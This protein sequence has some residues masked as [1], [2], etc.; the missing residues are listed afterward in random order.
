MPDA[1]QTIRELVTGFNQIQQQMGLTPLSANMVGFTPPQTPA[2]M[3]Q[4]GSKGPGDIAAE[5]AAQMNQ[6]VQVASRTFQAQSQ[7][8]QEFG[9]RMQNIKAQY[10]SPQAAQYMARTSGAP[11]FGTGGPLGDFPSPIYQT[12][13]EMGL[14]RPTLPPPGMRQPSG[15]AGTGFNAPMPAPFIPQPYM[16]LFPGGPYLGNMMP[17]VFGGEAPG[18]RFGEPWQRQAMQQEYMGNRSFSQAMAVTPTAFTTLPGAGLGMAGGA[19]MGARMGGA[20]GAVIGAGL[21]MVGGGIAGQP[22]FEGLGFGQLGEAITEPMVRT[23]AFGNQLE[24]MSRQ[25]VT[26]GPDLHALGRGLAQRPA[27]ETANQMQKMVERGEM[28]EFN[29]RDMMKVTGLAAQGGMMDMAQSG[30]QIASQARNI[31]RALQNFMQIAEE[32]DIQRAMQMMAHM[33]TMGMT[34]PETQIA[35]RNAQQFARMAGT[36][37][38]GLMSTAGAQGAM[39]FQQQ[40]LTGALGMEVGM[41]AAGM[42]RAAIAGGSFNPAQLALAGGQQ[43]LAQ[44]MME[45]SAANLNVRFPMMAA[46]SRNEQGELFVDPQRLEKI[47]S[48]KADLS[49]QIEMA[50]ANIDRLARA[51]GTSPE[52]VIS[53]ISSRTRELQD[54]M[55]RRLGPQGA[56]NMIIRQAL[57]IQ[58][59][60]GGS[61]DLATAIRSAS[62]GTMSINSAQSLARAAQNPDYWSSQQQSMLTDVPRL[63]QLEAARR[64]ATVDTADAAT[65]R[66]IF[67]PAYQAAGAVSD[68]GEGFNETIRDLRGGVASWFTGGGTTASGGRRFET[69]RRIGIDDA[70]ARREFNREL[71]GA[72][73]D[74][75]L[76]E[77]KMAGTGTRGEALTWQQE[78]S[79]QFNV[80]KEVVPAALTGGSSLAVRGGVAVAGGLVPDHPG[81]AQSRIVAQAR[82]RGGGWGTMAEYAPSITNLALAGGRGSRAWMGGG[83]TAGMGLFEEARG[84]SFADEMERKASGVAAFAQRSGAT[85]TQLKEHAVEYDRAAGEGG[86]ER[87]TLSRATEI[88]GYNLADRAKQSRVASMK[89]GAIMGSGMPII[90][91][92]IGAAAGY[93]FGKPENLSDDQMKEEYIKAEIEATGQSRAQVEKRVNADWNDPAKGSKLRDQVR[94]RMAQSGT[95]EAK[96]AV[97]AAEAA[98]GIG[99]AQNI[100]EAR[101]EAE[102]ALDLSTE[103]AISGGGVGTAKTIVGHAVGGGLGAAAGTLL[104]GPLGTVAGYLLGSSA[105]RKAAGPS[106]AQKK[107]FEETLMREKNDDVVLLAAANALEEDGDTTGARNIKDSIRAKDPDKYDALLEAARKMPGANDADKKKALAM[108]GK[109]VR[110]MSA[111]EAR[112]TTAGLREETKNIRKRAAFSE[113]IQK[114]ADEERRSYADVKAS[115]ETDEGLRK[116][117]QARAAEGGGFEA[118]GRGAGG[119]GERSLRKSTDQL[120][121]LGLDVAQFNKATNNLLQA[122]ENFKNAAIAGGLGR[123]AG[124]GKR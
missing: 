116:K 39:V 58:Q 34:V 124:Q 41:G 57:N 79:S 83:L 97:A 98:T 96:A 72:E 99:A 110:D 73:G 117:V 115:I 15:A 27:I 95:P 13:A 25:F 5:M 62:G 55:G 11:E 30:P 19:A 23:R 38:Q 104:G 52:R 102:K 63:R 65:R 16:P 123:A 35:V 82:A 22:L 2:G 43:G 119:E 31:A 94:Q 121:K 118:G 101:K 93:A 91:N 81:A 87:H 26:S 78:M 48:G 47:V 49:R 45:A 76:R 122:S 112:K 107:G 60:L 1:V 21:G 42:A 6:Q 90:G 77:G 108:Y 3:P 8:A 74:R 86:G 75:Y 59:E 109:K 80:L 28:G 32:P 40:G 18:G 29:M 33:R 113:G 120:G 53:E 44:T 12:P 70:V 17:Q 56:N 69:S 66:A 89:R 100:E 92:L 71:T 64:E 37:T 50:D 111:D 46:L 114:V 9:Q 36:T 14:Y 85:E 67:R 24:A 51:G 103:G 88:L 10:V 20:R 68:L 7:F 84:E 54:E 4:T 105:G 61:V 106:L